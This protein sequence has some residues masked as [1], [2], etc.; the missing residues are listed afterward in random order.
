MKLLNQYLRRGGTLDFQ[1]IVEVFRNSWQRYTVQKVVK[2]YLHNHPSPLNLIYRFLT[3]KEMTHRTNILDKQSFGYTLI[4]ELCV[5]LV[6][7][8]DSINFV[9]W[10][11][12]F[13]LRDTAKTP[14]TNFAAFIYYLLQNSKNINPV[15]ILSK[16]QDDFLDYLNDY[17]GGTEIAYSFQDM[18]TF[19]TY[20]SLSSLRQAK[21]IVNQRNYSLINSDHKMIRPSVITSLVKLGEVGGEIAMYQDSTS[22]SSKQSA[23]LRAINTLGELAQYVQENVFLPEQSIL[24]YI[25]EKWREIITTEAGIIGR[26]AEAKPVVNPYI[27]G[28]PVTGKL[29]VG[30]EDIFTQLEGYWIKEKCES[31]VLYGHRRM[32]KSS[33]LKNLGSRFGNKTIIVDFNMQGEVY[34]TS[35]SDLFYDLAIALYDS[36]PSSLQKSLSEPQPEQFFSKPETA[37]KRF[38]NQ[39]KSVR[40]GYRFII[41]IDE[42]EIL[43]RKIAEHYLQPD[44][45]DFFRYL[46]QTYEWLILAFAGLYTL[47]E[48]RE[49]Y[50]HPLYSSVAATRVSFLDY[51]AAYSLITQPSEDFDL[52]YTQDAI[53]LIFNLTSG[54]PFLVQL[55]CRELVSQYNTQFK[56]REKCFTWEDVQNITNNPDFFQGD[57]NA[58]F[59]GIWS[60]ASTSE[61]SGQLHIL[62]QLCIQSYT[63]RELAQL[64]SLSLEQ[65]EE[66]LNTLIT[67]DVIKLQGESYIYNVELMRC[68]VCANLNKQ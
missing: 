64:T 66:A 30:R 65:V 46:I 43:E 20:E 55:I 62:N 2:Q 16:Q 35:E 9:A 38:L 45:L 26:V 54:Q 32:G 5:K 1:K 29:F 67:H 56:E 42:F 57:A 14:L 21:K 3:D 51:Q 7:R 60:Q 68:W 19:L 4:A 48:R 44:L 61:P 49:D 27:A 59:S 10:L 12:T 28:N 39:L 53:E 41:T 34:I 63:A 25:V 23:V 17:P 31:V 40:D 18:K 37:F 6:R 33:I 50:W 36:L 52:N 8:D 24:K 22:Q 13:W 15:S 47:Q 58:Y 11:I